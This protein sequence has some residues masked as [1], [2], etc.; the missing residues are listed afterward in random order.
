MRLYEEAEKIRF[1]GI[2]GYRFG[3][4]VMLGMAAAATVIGFLCWAKRCEKGT[5]PL[6]VFLSILL[7]AAGSRIS[8]CLMNQELGAMMP[9]KSWGRISD[10]G[11]AMTGVVAGAIL[12]GWI[13]AR[14]TKQKTGKILDIIACALPV[15]MAM[16]RTGEG[17]IP[18][19][20]YSRELSTEFLKGTFLAFSDEYGSY[21]ATW[22]VAGIVMLILFPILIFD[23]I[24][25]VKDGDTCILFFMIFGGCS[26]LLESLRYD[27][28][29]SISFVGLEQVL[30]AVFLGIG[31]F[32]AAGQAGKKRKKAAVAAVISV[33]AT[34]GISVGLEFALDRTNI[35]KILI[36]AVYIL[37]VASPVILGLR[38]RN[39]ARA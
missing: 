3:F 25:S 36:Y 1:L 4:F 16:E 34:V 9:L 28:F 21:L 32:A 31:V 8:F 19:F 24:R 17:C 37:A 33:F 11:W 26:I 2:E 13:T 6:L 10:G 18:E 35:N 20:D 23:I 29:L 39:K 27:R 15:F 38:L 12:A 14:V 22:K 30:A 7:G 5:A